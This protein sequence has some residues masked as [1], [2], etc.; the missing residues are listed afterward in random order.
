MPIYEYECAKC[1]RVS[2]FLVR[3]VSAHEAPK[4][5]KCGHPKM[6]RAISRF[7]AAKG[8]R[9]DEGG[10]AGAGG[11]APD[12]DAA[13]P[14]G[15]D[16]EGGGPMPDLSAFEGLDENNPRSMGR[17]MRQLAGQTGEALDPEME[18]V[19]RRLEA[20]ED[21]E[22]IE[23]RMGDALGGGGGGGGDELYDG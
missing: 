15:P 22:K 13:G 6:S 12:A 1:G 5:P 11:F 21:P 9:K 16:D 10:A 19:C 17:A 2:S 18:E 20:G 3:N 4:C 7:A 14:G 8:G 23:D